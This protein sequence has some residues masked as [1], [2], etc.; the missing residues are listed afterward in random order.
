MW[1]LFCLT[2]LPLF[3][4]S[5]LNALLNTI[6]FSCFASRPLHLQFHLLK[7]D[8]PLVFMWF[9][10]VLT[11]LL[12]CYL[13]DE[14]HPIHLIKMA[15]SAFVLPCP[16]SCS[17]LLLFF[18]HEDTYHLLITWLS[19]FSLMNV[20]SL[21]AGISSLLYPLCLKWWQHAQSSRVK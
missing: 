3:S 11:T 17:D 6:M 13:F 1:C 19:I 15:K 12:K 21:R 4:S 14:A 9:L 7:V 5:H 20:N 2:S 18:F 8:L 16:L 10:S